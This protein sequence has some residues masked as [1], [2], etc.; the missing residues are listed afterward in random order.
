[1]ADRDRPY[2]QFNFLVNL[3]GGTDPSSIQG[4]FQEVTGLS[5]ELAQQDYRVGNAPHN[6]VIK[7]TGLNKAADM[8][9]KRGII[10][11]TALF[12]WVNDVREGTANHRRTITVELQGEDHHTVARWTLNEARPL[13]YTLGSLNAKGNDAAMEE[14]VIAY[15]RLQVERV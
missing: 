3:G 8:T 6:N 10:N 11:P 15:E 1:M 4:G 2:M 13:K 9:L 7:L 14:L 12:D 5:T